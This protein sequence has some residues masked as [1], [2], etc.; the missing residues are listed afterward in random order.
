MKEL[1][2]AAGKAVLEKIE[3][4]YESGASA[5]MILAENNASSTIGKIIAIA[6][7]SGEDE[8]SEFKVGDEVAFS[9]M[10]ASVVKVENKIYHVIEQ[11]EILGKIKELKK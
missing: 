9:D 11:N 1:V 4:E 2:P 3:K 7:P 8:K 5:G 10:V 6:D